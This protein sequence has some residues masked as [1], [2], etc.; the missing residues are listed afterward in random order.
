MAAALAAGVLADWPGDAPASTRR[1]RVE[2]RRERKGG[3]E[4]EEEGEKGR[5]RGGY[6]NDELVA[7]VKTGRDRWRRREFTR[8]RRVQ[9]HSSPARRVLGPSSMAIVTHG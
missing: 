5:E 4:R 2:L 3:K 9:G 8:R 7:M 1:R 6:I